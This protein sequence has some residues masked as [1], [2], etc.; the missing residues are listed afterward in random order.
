MDAAPKSCPLLKIGQLAKL[1]GKTARA[2]RFY[3]DRELL[4]PET[5]TDS[6]YRLYG[7]EA[8]LRIEWIDR[9][10]EMGF[11]LTEVAE[12]MSSLKSYKTGPKA[13]E[14]LRSFYSEKLDESRNR[15]AMLERL[16]GELESSITYLDACQTCRVQDH[17][18][19]CLCCDRLPVETPRPHLVSAAVKAIN[20]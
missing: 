12:F 14:H 18:S 16:A 1:T 17:P 20:S 5:R 10:Q 19:M 13:M 15:I 3:E 2:I 9:L 11:S 8:V 7:E 6:G 4:F